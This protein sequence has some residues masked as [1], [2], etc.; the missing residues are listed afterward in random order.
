MIRDPG[1]N[2]I[3]AFDAVLAD[4]GITRPCGATSVRVRCGTFLL[5]RCH[6]RRELQ[7][8]PGYSPDQR[9]PRTPGYRCVVRSASGQAGPSSPAPRRSTLCRGVFPILG[10][11]TAGT[12]LRPSR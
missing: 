3:T 12:C 5:Y 2:F 8:C 9:Q 11:R 10:N 7:S 6:P 1:S 4:A